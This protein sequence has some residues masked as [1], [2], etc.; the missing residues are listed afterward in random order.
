MHGHPVTTREED[1]STAG[2]IGHMTR[3]QRTALFAVA[4]IP[5]GFPPLVYVWLIVHV[6]WGIARSANIAEIGPVEGGT[7]W[8][9]G[10]AAI[11]ATLIQWPFY[12]AWAAMSRELT[13]RQRIAWMIVIILLNMFAIPWFLWCKY[14]GKTRDGLLSLVGWKGLRDFLSRP[15]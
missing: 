10:W 12:L 7:L 14:R 11:Y 8:W 1:Q 3:T 5:A 2:P 4:S 13:I 15:R 6:F 9:C